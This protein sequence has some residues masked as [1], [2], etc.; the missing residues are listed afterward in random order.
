MHSLISTAVDDA[1]TPGH[2]NE[3]LRQSRSSTGQ[4]NTRYM[5]IEFIQRLAR[6]LLELITEFPGKHRR[7]RARPHN[8]MLSGHI[9]LALAS[10]AILIAFV[11][12]RVPATLHGLHARVRA[13][14]RSLAHRHDTTHDKSTNERNGSYGDACDNKL[15]LMLTQSGRV[16]HRE[17]T[18]ASAPRCIYI[19]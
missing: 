19:Y 3:R 2:Y 7:A 15:I 8:E 11:R 16:A 17:C 13:R 9:L 5:L 18:C 6:S 1:L 4:A 14:A 12:R 10:H